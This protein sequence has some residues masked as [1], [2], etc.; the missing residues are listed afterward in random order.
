MKELRSDEVI[1]AHQICDS[2]NKID[3]IKSVLSL[4]C[5]LADICL[6]RKNIIYDS[7]DTME[8]VTLDMI[9]AAPD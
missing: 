4:L 6:K 8:T 1:L 3:E 7:T 9:S 2:F 5:F